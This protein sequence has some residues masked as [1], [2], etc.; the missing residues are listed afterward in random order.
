M[1]ALEVSKK[2]SA[3]IQGSEDDPLSRRQPEGQSIALRSRVFDWLP[4]PH[5]IMPKAY[6]ENLG[7][8]K[9]AAE[10]TIRSR[11]SELLARPFWSRIIADRSSHT[12]IQSGHLRYRQ[13]DTSSGGKGCSG[14]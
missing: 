12:S 6:T 7:A 10:R 2:L 14:H 11:G 13:F 8:D 1:S 4:L 3:S 9:R 5:Q